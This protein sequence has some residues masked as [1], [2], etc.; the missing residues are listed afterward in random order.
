MSK[1]V[2]VIEDNEQNRTLLRDV[3]GYHGYLVIEAANGAEGIQ[4]AREQRPDLILLDIQM[5]VING[6]EAAKILKNDPA[7]RH[8]KVVVITSFAMKFEQDEIVAT[9]IDDYIAKP[10][11]IRELH[12]VVKRH[13]G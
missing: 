6:F 5:P 8:I 3:L 10:I 2:L 4:Q 7:T 12:E 11:D 1:K 13:I 9:G